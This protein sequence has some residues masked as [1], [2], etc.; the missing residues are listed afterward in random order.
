MSPI[1]RKE[2]AVH[3][4]EP[5]SRL[6]LHSCE[7][8]EPDLEPGTEAEGLPAWGAEACGVRVPGR[9]RPARRNVPEPR[10]EAA[11]GVPELAR[12]WGAG[13]VPRG[14][15]SLIRPGPAGRS[16]AGDV[17][18]SCHEAGGRDPRRALRRS[19]GGPGGC[20]VG[21]AWGGVSASF[22]REWGVGQGWADCSRRSGL[23][24][25]LAQILR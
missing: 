14:R 2:T 19:P 1:C 8:S 9:P 23:F 21:G 24:E 5:S 12:R 22:P 13:R 11:A 18:R 15:L 6:R 17:P 25:T 7:V 3:R 10:P 4:S 16:P 20:R